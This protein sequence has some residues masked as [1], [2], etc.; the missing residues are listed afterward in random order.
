MTKIIFE[1]HETHTVTLKKTME[2]TVDELESAGITEKQ[3]IKYLQD[4]DLDDETADICWDL[5]INFAELLEEDEDW[6]SDRKG[7]TEVN[8]Y[9]RE[10]IDDA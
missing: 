10:T 3:F 5:T 9:Y 7:F 8:H 6:V 2:I 1:K 4:E